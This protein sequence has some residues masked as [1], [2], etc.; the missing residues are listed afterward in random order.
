MSTPPRLQLPQQRPP[1][2]DRAAW[3]PYNFV[4]LPERVVTP[5]TDPEQLPDHDTYADTRYPRT[6]YFDV[7]LTT[8]SPLYVRCPL[9]LSNFLRQER[10]EDQNL[11]FRQQV[12]N[13]P[14]FFYTRDPQVPVIPGSSLRG[15]LRSVL[16][17]VS[18]G[19]MESVTKTRLFFRTVDTTSVGEHYRRRM[20]NVETGFLQRTGE[21]YVIKV[22]DRARVLRSTL[23]SNL[24]NGQG[25]GKTPTWQGQPRQWMPVWVQLSRNGPLV[26]HIAYEP[27][28]HA[29]EGRL[30]ITGDVPRKKKEFVFLLPADKAEEIR[31]PQAV[32][33]RF[34]DDDQLTQ[35]QERAF[36]Q[37]RP[38]NKSRARAGLVR[39]DPGEP[40][41]PV[42]FLRENGQ[43]TFFGRAG[44][45]RLPYHQGPLDFVP[46][47]LRR[48]ED[49]DYAEAIFGY[50]KG[51]AP[52]HPQGSKVRAYASRVFVSDAT[53]V[54]GQSDIWLATEPITP[55]ILA[56]PKP[57]AFQ[58][59]LV[60]T[61]DN[62]GSLKHYGSNTPRETVI[63]GHKR[64]WHQGL[65]SHLAMELIRAMI[66]EG[67]DKL[68]EIRRN[69]T[70]GKPDTQHTQFKPVKPEVQFT[71]RI[72]FENLSDAELGALCWTLHPVGKAEMTYCHSL[73][74]GKPLGMGAVH[75]DATL[76]LTDRARRYGALFEGD[77]WQTGIAGAG[78][79]LAERTTLERHTDAFE[80]HMHDQL[81]PHAPR[82]PLSSMPRL[83]ALLQM[84]EW[85][86]FTPVAEES[87]PSVLERNPQVRY[88]QIQGATNDYRQRPVLPGPLRIDS[89]TAPTAR[90][91]RTHEGRSSTG[92]GAS[93]RRDT[94][95]QS[96]MGTARGAAPAGPP[97]HETS[98]GFGNMRVTQT[99]QPPASA[100]AQER[101]TKE[102]VTLLEATKNRKAFVETTEGERVI[103]TNLP[104]YPPNQTGR[105]CRAEVVRSDGKVLRATFEYWE[106]G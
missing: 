65:G 82:M 84:L 29:H 44:M 61:S 91:T 34:H 63:R 43:L 36:P 3:A 59:Y 104:A 50:V 27:T 77:A 88:M 66:D 56:T 52:Q 38:Q 15:M 78:E 69:E 72:F 100:P 96:S 70:D 81:Q 39:T 4:P 99:S 93:S 53:L 13:T 23:G 98:Q 97:A 9:T 21:H 6:G 60:Q 67:Q 54:T 55:K 1:R 30:V 103:C 101:K 42:F 46:D 25:P 89:P 80:Q 90:V 8:K 31:V 32:V 73:G 86:G 37:N 87:D 48:P 64:Y 47:A 102:A 83:A 22:C 49:I 18:Y 20:Q 11:S 95:R 17:I 12:K 51:H 10:G 45:F 75:L 5:A 16:E 94:A 57:T 62:Q 76:Y 28:P 41:D 24:Y 33:D 14:E 26:E 35:W 58:H 105:R 19:K 2:P 68:C 7:T 106:K 71:F 85:P 79:R 40:G 74:M 92:S